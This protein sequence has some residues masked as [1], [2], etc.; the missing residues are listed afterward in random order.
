MRITSDLLLGLGAQVPLSS[1]NGAD[2]PYAGLDSDPTIDVNRALTP[3]DL[4]E[5]PTVGTAVVNPSGT[6]L[7]VPYSQWSFDTDM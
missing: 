2:Q 5:Q 6:L 7:F 4:V 3:R 1:L